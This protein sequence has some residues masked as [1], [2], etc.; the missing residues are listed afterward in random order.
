MMLLPVVI[1]IVLFARVMI[2]R[3]HVFIASRF[4]KKFDLLSLGDAAA[5]SEA[6]PRQDRTDQD[7]AE[8]ISLRERAKNSL[9]G[10]ARWAL[11]PFT[12]DEMDDLRVGSQAAFYLSLS[13]SYFTL[14]RWGENLGLGVRV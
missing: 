1:R 2:N 4:K 14:S 6:S 3:F 8:K 7:P 10:V 12:E 11:V 13:W 9:R 5:A